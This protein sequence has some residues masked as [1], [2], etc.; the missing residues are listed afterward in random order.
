MKLTA[1]FVGFEALQNKLSN[2][3]DKALRVSLKSAAL[4]GAAI[5]RNQARADAPVFEGKIPKGHAPAGT[6]KK[7]IISRGSR[8]YSTPNKAVA[9]VTFK[10]ITKVYSNTAANIRAGRAG[11]KY[12][13]YGDV[14]YWVFVEKGIN[15]TRPFLKQAFESSKN[16]AA[17][18]VKE[19]L[20]LKVEQYWNKGG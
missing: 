19:Q 20:T 11:K 7:S 8:R 4:A 13:S 3:T 2:M 1:D 9:V 18:K 15:K 14:F 5:V 12:S 16:E 10:Q 6:L 17:E